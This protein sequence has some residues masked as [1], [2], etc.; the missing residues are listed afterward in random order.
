MDMRPVRLLACVATMLCASGVCVAVASA[1]DTGSPSILCL[2]KGCQNLEGTLTG[3]NVKLVTSK[4]AKIPEAEGI[5]ASLKNC[6]TVAGTE[7]KDVRLCKDV[8]IMFA[9]VKVESTKCNTEG[10]ANGTVLALF[11]L[12]M[13]SE[14]TSEGALVPLL[15]ARVLNSKLEPLPITL[16][17]GAAFKFEVRGTLGCLFTPGLKNVVTTEMLEL[18]CK[19]KE[20]E[21]ETGTCQQLCELLQEAPFEANLGS[22]FEPGW[23]ELHAEGSPSKDVFIDD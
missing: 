6:E 7:E 4:N 1:E 12:H 18:S 5:E 2:V 10:D 19:V 17:C 13:A 9:G 15:L 22:G 23:M 14:T 8:T 16:K 20:K 21:A 3:G 11:D